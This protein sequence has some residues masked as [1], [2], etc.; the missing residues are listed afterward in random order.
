MA[1]GDIV[2]Q[3]GTIVTAADIQQIAAAVKSQL[4]QESK[5]LTQYEEVSSLSGVSSLPGLHI[6]GSTATLVR[7]ALSILQGV[8]GKTPE[9]SAS[10]TALQWRYTGD[11][12]WKTLVQLSLLKG[13]PGVKVMLRKGETGIEW[14]Y[15]NDNL[16]QTLIAMADLSFSYEDLTDEQ[17]QEIAKKPVLDNVTVTSGESASGSFSANGVDDKGNPKYNLS[18]VVPKGDK[19]DTGKTP[20]LE[21]GN[22]VTLDPTDN[23]SVSLTPDEPDSAGN[24]VYKLNMSIPKG[25]PGEGSGNVYVNPAG[26]LAAKQYAFKPQADNS[27]TGSFVEVEATG[28]GAVDITDIVDP[29]FSNSQTSISEE[30]Y[31][32]L[33][34]YIES[35]AHMLYAPADSSYVCSF[36]GLLYEGIILN[37][38]LSQFETGFQVASLLINPDY[39]VVNYSFEVPS[40]GYVGKGMMAGY[41]KPSEYSTISDSNSINQAIGKLEAGLNALQ[42]GGGSSTEVVDN[43]YYLPI[44]LLNLTSDSTDEEIV[45]A[46]G[47]ISKLEEVFDYMTSGKAGRFAIYS[48]GFMMLNVDAMS[49]FGTSITIAINDLIKEYVVYIKIGS[50][51]GNGS[52]KR[53]YPKGYAL[54]SE[55]FYLSSSSTSEE[56]STAVGGESGLKSIIQASRDRNRLVI[57]SSNPELGLNNVNIEVDVTDISETDDEMSISFLKH[58]PYLWGGM[59]GIL[60]IAY[61]KS[62]G[63]FRLSITNVFS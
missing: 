42:E 4:A 52:V 60:F 12:E 35:G 40:L 36:F 62:T 44:A 9:L 56:I 10:S 63:T 53:I 32:K 22:V 3:S 50:S 1:A 19:G 28:G 27:A 34:G 55:L 5:D 30:N 37:A 14:K 39:N 21:V 48:N 6:S 54:K 43:T 20:V 59:G 46:F 18:L 58:Y 51:G 47:G 31:N 23:A 38:F 17:K 41:S 61:T 2:L 7:V 16:W 29:I 11:T 33:K 49:A 45:E 15:E 26:L 24:P 8:E 57:L 25:A 13:D